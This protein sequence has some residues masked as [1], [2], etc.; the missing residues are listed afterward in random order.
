VSSTAGGVSRGSEISNVYENLTTNTS[1]LTTGFSD[2]PMPDHYPSVRERKLHITQQELKDYLRLYV[3]TFNLTPRIQVNTEVVGVKKEGGKWKVTTSQT[4]SDKGRNEEVRDF[5]AVCVCTGNYFHPRPYTLGSYSFSS[6]DL[7]EGGSNLA[8]TT[9]AKETG[10]Q[11]CHSAHYRRP[12]PFAGKRVVV[13][14]FGNS[15]ID[16]AADIADGKREAGTTTAPSTSIISANHNPLIAVKA[17]P[18]CTAADWAKLSFASLSMPAW[19]TRRVTFWKFKSIL[20]G[21][22]EQYSVNL[23]RRLQTKSTGKVLAPAN[24]AALLHS[25]RVQ[26]EGE[27]EKVEGERRVRTKEGKI[28]EEVEAIV[29]TTGYVR[30]Y[31]FISTNGDTP[32][33]EV[34]SNTLQCLYRHVFH[35]DDPTLT[36][37]G[38]NQNVIPLPLCELQA[39]WIAAVYTQKATLPPQSKQREDTTRQVEVLTRAGGSPSQY[40]SLDQLKYSLFIAD[41][42]GI[43]VRPKWLSYPL[44]LNFHLLF[45]IAFPAVWRLGEERREGFDAV[46]ELLRCRSLQKEMVEAEKKRRSEQ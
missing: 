43:P 2:L 6:R 44:W 27:L 25:G 45:G 16:I 7:L 29:L 22:P 1:T 11:L 34:V 14:G 9:F 36:F 18:D 24:I 41:Q 15:G 5:D 39:R 20:R 40:H 26:I 10:I 33:V 17:F 3:D 21:L 46:R 13:V 42:L 35:I 4:G 31:D 8:I 32:K 38:L 12:D 37:V 19:L 28:I 30:T 23:W